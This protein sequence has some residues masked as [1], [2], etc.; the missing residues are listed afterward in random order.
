MTTQTPKPTDQTPEVVAPL[1]PESA[2]TN[3]YWT[4]G[5]TEIFNLQTT[6]RGIV[7][8]AQLDTHFTSVDKAL[9]R[10]VKQGGHA[11]PIGV[12]PSQPAPSA[13]LDPS[14]KIALEEGNK[15]LATSIQEGQAII[16]DFVYDGVEECDGLTIIPQPGDLV[17]LDFTREGFK[18]PVIKAT[19]WKHTR[20][21]DLLKWTTSADVSKAAKFTLAC[22]V[23][24]KLGKEYTTKENENRRY[25]DIV[26]V[27]LA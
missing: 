21:Q 20:A 8:P 22:K 2:S 5:T 19:K 17:D 18:W 12:Q 15:E 14:A 13:P 16:L 3:F 7:S 27:R 25:K 4:L 6:I 23:Y 11:K 10:V 26:G 1:S 9:Q 24:Y